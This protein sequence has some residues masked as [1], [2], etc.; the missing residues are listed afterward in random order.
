MSDIVKSSYLTDPY[1]RTRASSSDT[2]RRGTIASYTVDPHGRTRASSAEEICGIKKIYI[3][4]LAIAQ[5]AF[6]PPKVNFRPNFS[7]R[8]IKHFFSKT[9][10]NPLYRN[11]N[12]VPH[13]ACKIRGDTTYLPRKQDLPP[14]LSKSAFRLAYATIGHTK[15]W[16]DFVV[17]NADIRHYHVFIQGKEFIVEAYAKTDVERLFNE[18]S[19]LRLESNQYNS[20]KAY[21]YPDEDP[22]YPQI[23]EVS[24]EKK[25]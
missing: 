15:Q 23:Y 4:R 5:G 13:Y 12:N 9:S 1:G 3:I 8:V 22:L 19:N 18:I 20:S 10:S 17:E 7:P 16:R 6:Y 14:K 21:Q 24:Y 11:I 25:H 2:P